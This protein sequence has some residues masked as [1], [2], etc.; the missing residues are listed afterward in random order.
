M[1]PTVL[2]AHQTRSRASLE[3]LVQAAREILEK[4]GLAGATIPRIAA[5]AGLSPGSV[6]R[7][8]PDKDALLQEVFLRFLRRNSERAEQRLKPELWD[9]KELHDM[10]N[11]LIGGMLQGYRTNPGLLRA[12]LQ[13][14]EQHPDSKFRKEAE[15]LEGRVL[16]LI[17][18]L[19]LTRRR[20]IRHPNP[21]LAVP[22]GFLIVIFALREMFLRADIRKEWPSLLPGTE[23]QLD[24][25]LPEVF[26]RYLG[27]G[28]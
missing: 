7:R 18:E 3:R 25:E 2:P 13:F 22:L 1:A 9:D 28:K 20:Q 8:F 27:V 15:G 21:D 12:L 6:Y 5:R 17:T 23:Q 19:F 10:A 26:L 16:K 11:G 14:F 24:T 4:D